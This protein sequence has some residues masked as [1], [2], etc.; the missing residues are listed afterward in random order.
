MRQ[1]IGIVQAFQHKPCVLVLDEP[2]EGLDPVMKERFVELLAEHRDAGGTTFLSSHIL[3]EVEQTTERVAV[4]KAGRVVR[5]GA[6]AGL[7]GERVRHC[8]LVLKE[9][10][11]HPAVLDLEGVSGLVSDG[12]VHRFEFRGD[13][14]ALM[15]RIGRL[16]VQEFLSEPEHLAETFFEIY[17]E[18][19]TDGTP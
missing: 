8:T 14:E 4:I 12:L 17:G 5:T 7:T 2:T 6:T 19:G 10:P 11:A 16:A 9:P 15:R 18:A 13:M 1:K 3:S